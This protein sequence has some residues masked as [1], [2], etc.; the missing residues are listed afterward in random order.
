M[1]FFVLANGTPSGFFS[2]PRGL[3]QKDPLSPLFSVIVMGALSKMISDLV[4]EGLLSEEWWCCQHL[5]PFVC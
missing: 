5:S 4:D 2:S 1:R 3:R